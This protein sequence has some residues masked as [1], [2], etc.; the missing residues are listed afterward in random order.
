MS[1]SSKV[2]FKVPSFE[3]I[4]TSEMASPPVNPAT[5]K[6]RNSFFKVGDKTFEVKHKLGE[7][8]C[9]S[10][11]YAVSEDGTEGI[12]KTEKP[13]ENK[14][15]THGKTLLVE[16]ELTGI[17]NGV[18]AFSGD[19]SAEDKP[20]RMYTIFKRGHTLFDALPRIHSSIYF[21]N[22]MI[23]VFRDLLHTIGRG[24]IQQDLVPRN[25]I[26]SE[27]NGVSEAGAVDFEHG[28]K[29]GDPKEIF[30]FDSEMYPQLPPEINIIN[31]KLFGKQVALPSM[32]AYGAG[33]LLLASYET[34]KDLFSTDIAKEIKAIYEG[35][36]KKTP[37]ERITLADATQQLEALA[38]KNMDV[39]RDSFGS[40]LNTALQKL[41]NNFESKQVENVLGKWCCVAEAKLCFERLSRKRFLREYTELDLI[42]NEEIINAA[43]FSFE[44]KSFKA[45]V[46][47][48]RL[49]EI[50]KGDV[51]RLLV[52]L[53]YL[54]LAKPAHAVDVLNF[55]DKDFL[56]S[57]VKRGE[58]LEEGLKIIAEK[59]GCDYL[60]GLTDA[61]KG[62]AEMHQVLKTALAGV[63]GGLVRE[64]SEVGAMSSSMAV[65]YHF[66]PETTAATA[67]MRRRSF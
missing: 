4:S 13:D 42:I 32:D 56:E 48:E 64:S 34:C 6:R 15:F 1:S 46:V 59:V 58:R 55:L 65:N 16:A 17:K 30:Y 38:Q 60:E 53:S 40:S 43:R 66:T 57:I 2:E 36:R 26:V 19:V 27:K 51:V 12:V 8:G 18:A 14:K 22:T 28:S 24:V 21:F 7:G 5:G 45:E 47:R 23:A 33:Y 52:F 50:F 10:V 61:F 39:F 62:F 20:C 54:D 29:I 63:G 37:S 25:V 67:G 41:E 49:T 11:F 35:L 31:G 9:G 3:Y 44:S